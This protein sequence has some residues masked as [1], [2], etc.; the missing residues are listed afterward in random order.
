MNDTQDD[1]CHKSDAVN[2][3]NDA[4]FWVLNIGSVV[5]GVGYACIPAI[6]LSYIDDNCKT[7]TTALFAG[8]YI[9]NVICDVVIYA[10]C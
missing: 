10:F 4:A 9:Q 1:Q 3:Q 6:A 7:E 2:A 5:W 8:S